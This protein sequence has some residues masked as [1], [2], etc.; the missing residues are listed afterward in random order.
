[1]ADGFDLAHAAREQMLPSGKTTVLANRVAWALSHLFQAGL[2]ERPERG[3]YRITARGRAVAAEHPERVD[4]ALLSQFADY[5]SFRARGRAPAASTAAT[6][7]APAEQGTPRERL[8]AAYGELRTSLALEL[9]ESVLAQSPSFFE[10]LVLDVLQGMGYGGSLVNA[11]EKL[12]RTGD[13]GVDGVIREDPLGL[14]LIYVQAKRWTNVVGRPEIQRFV[15][16]L[17]GQRASKGV[18]IT[19]SS[20]S[21]E[22]IQFAGGVTPRTV[23][24]EGAE[25]ADLMIEHGVGV[26]VSDVYKVGRVDLDYFVADDE[27]EGFGATP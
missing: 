12:G 10:K 13:E 16:A 25:L 26:T 19:T 21:A 6:S 4:M 7:T 15:G 3:V 8:E 14:D 22:A 2:I 27:D 1:M 9:L 20:F 18:F 11:A 24:I 23:L 17:Q 5:R